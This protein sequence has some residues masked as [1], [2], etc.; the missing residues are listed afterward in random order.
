MTTIIV[1]DEVAALEAER[2]SSAP[3]SRRANTKS[4]TRRYHRAVP[5]PW[6]CV[7]PLKA[8]RHPLTTSPNIYSTR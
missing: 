4:P 6:R 7:G 2:T 1:H 8:P 5:R 3:C